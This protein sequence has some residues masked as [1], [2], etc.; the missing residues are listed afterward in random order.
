MFGTILS[1]VWKLQNSAVSTKTTPFTCLQDGT[2]ALTVRDTK[3]WLQAN[4]PAFIERN[5]FEPTGLSRLGCHAG[6]VP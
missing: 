6:K 1:C 3:N 2:P 4:C 5:E